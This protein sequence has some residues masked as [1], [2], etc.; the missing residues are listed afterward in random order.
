MLFPGRLT[1]RGRQ[2]PIAVLQWL[3][4]LQRSK[5]WPSWQLRLRGD[6]R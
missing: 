4:W 5:Q 2:L 6:F 1:V 3:P